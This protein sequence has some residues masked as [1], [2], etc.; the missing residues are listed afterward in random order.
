M[1]Y[2]WA[3]Q[4]A[5][6][7]LKGGNPATLVPVPYKIHNLYLNTASAAFDNLTLPPT[8]LKSAYQTEDK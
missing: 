4:V 2:A 1:G 3:K 5:I 6:P 8:L 7:V